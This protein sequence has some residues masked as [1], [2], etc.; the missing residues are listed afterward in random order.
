MPISHLLHSDYEDT[1]HKT[2][3]AHPNNRRYDKLSLYQ[4]SSVDIDGMY[5]PNVG[6]G[7][8]ELENVNPNAVTAKKQTNMVIPAT[9]PQNSPNPFLLI[10]FNTNE[11]TF[12]IS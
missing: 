7:R 12:I 2:V 11:E 10:G 5:F 3:P 9:N 4:L 8:K 6:V 1:A